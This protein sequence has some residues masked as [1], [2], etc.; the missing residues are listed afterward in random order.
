MRNNKTNLISRK[1]ELPLK[2]DSTSLFLQIM[3]SIAVFLFGLTLS[4]VL[5][6][7]SMLK[8]WNESIMGSLTVQIL[9]INAVSV[10]KAEEETLINQQ[11]AI[12]VL[13][14]EPD[15]EKVTPLT[16]NQLQDLIRPWLGD[17]INIENLP[18]PRLLDVRLKSGANLDYL[19]LAEK[20]AEAAPYASLDNHKLWLNKLINFADGLKML[21]L[22][23]LI[24]VVTVT[25]GAIFYT[26]KTSLSLHEYV[27][28]I[29]HQMGAK[30]TYV[31]QQYAKR[32]AFLG[33]TGG[34]VGL[35][36]AIPT[37]FIISHLAQQI[38]GGIIS[39]AGLS[40]FDWLW[41]IIL[42]LFSSF[43]AMATAYLTVK[44]TLGKM[45]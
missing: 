24:L 18:L 31:A 42:P 12:D 14:A 26:T 21:A 22:I 23:V 29:L 20:L 28:G 2:G 16:D 5:S 33:L 36:F 45:M 40:F 38:E 9:P 32:N 25:S 39:E 30:D 17:G 41:I 1:E 27:I 35:V 19:A 10:Q 13:E 11:K 44:R 43:I 15:V 3:V 6:I 4:G 37:I 7:D 8:N 34:V